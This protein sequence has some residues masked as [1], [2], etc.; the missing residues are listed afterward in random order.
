L[1]GG[2]TDLISDILATPGLDAWTIGPD[3]KADR[4]HWL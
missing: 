4:D 2:L 3:D 1:V